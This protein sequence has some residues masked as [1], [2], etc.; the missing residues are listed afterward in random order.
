LKDFSKANRGRDFEELL[1]L[2]H[3][4]YQADGMAV[5]HKIPTEFL[6]LRNGSGRVVSCKVEHKSCV[7]YLGRYKDI[8]VAVEAKHTKAKRIAYDAVQDHQ[9]EFL[10]DWIG[11]TGAVGIVVVSFNMDRFFAIPWEF[12]RLPRQE[13]NKG[14]KAKFQIGSVGFNWTSNGM[15]SVSPDELLP[16]W[17]IKQEGR[18]VLPYLSVIDKMAV[19]DG[20]YQWSKA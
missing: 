15:A 13:W 16:E 9:A 7:D 6:P 2:A 19:Q 11:K 3:S 17:E 4:R 1:N 20:G 18:F 5:V 10:D 14:V 8:P 12:W